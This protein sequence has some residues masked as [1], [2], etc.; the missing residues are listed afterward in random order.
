MSALFD[1]NN[2]CT[3]DPAITHWWST[4]PPLLSSIAR[5]WFDAIKDC[6]PDILE[7]LHD[8]YPT[9]CINR[10]AFA[11]VGV[12][13]AHI[14]IAFFYGAHLADPARLLEGSGKN[15][16]HVKIRPENPVPYDALY[17]LIQ[18]AYKDIHQ[19]IS[20][21]TPLVKSHKLTDLVNI[22]KKIA[23]RLN[24]AGIFNADELR[25]V[26]AVEAHRRIK[27]LYPDETLPVCYYLYSFEGALTGLHWDKIPEQRKQ[28]L[29]QEIEKD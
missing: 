2:T 27:A 17:E 19:R 9:A 29:R 26:G 21:L 4:K 23:G 6:G 14:N 8:G 25:L 3:A 20:L 5:E 28:Q 7:V 10:Y 24:E 1:L 22:G 11:Y 15:M 12:F 16:R 13:K 18:N